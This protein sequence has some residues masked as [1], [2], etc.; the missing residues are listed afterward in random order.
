MSV[1]YVTIPKEFRKG[2]GT[3]SR[4]LSDKLNVTGEEG[5]VDNALKIVGDIDVKKTGAVAVVA[6][7]K[8]GRVEGMKFVIRGASLQS[9]VPVQKIYAGDNK[10]VSIRVKVNLELFQFPAGGNGARNI[11][12]WLDMSAVEWDMV[13]MEGDQEVVLTPE[14][15]VELGVSEHKFALRA[16]ML[17][18]CKQA[19]VYVSIIPVG[20]KEVRAKIA[21]WRME[22]EENSEAI[23]SVPLAVKGKEKDKAKYVVTLPVGP[24]EKMGDNM[25]MGWLPLLDYGE[26][27]G[28]AQAG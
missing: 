26:P 21:A 17:T 12:A 15:R 13:T 2:E 11:S 20:A 18:D 14:K 5:D 25:N 19:G 27:E 16:T 6:S 22:I 7:I 3:L 1:N 10:D 28:M 8:D 9:T 23:P 24:L 4:E